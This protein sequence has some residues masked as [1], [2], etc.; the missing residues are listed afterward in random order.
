MN[1]QFDYAPVR[2]PTEAYLDRLA[3]ARWRE[4]VIPATSWGSPGMRI[5]NLEGIGGLEIGVISAMVLPVVQGIASGAYGRNFAFGIL[6]SDEPVTQWITAVS[7][8]SHAPIFLSASTV[9]TPRA[10]RPVGTLTATEAS[11]LDTVIALGGAATAAQLAAQ[12]QLEAAAAN[13]RLT[14]LERKGFLIRYAR[15]RRDGDLFVDPGTRAQSVE[16]ASQ[17]GQVAQVAEIELPAEVA[18]SVQAL[19]VQQ[20]RSPNVVLAEAWRM[21]L[22]SHI[23]E[24]NAAVAV[25]RLELDQADASPEGHIDE[26]AL[27]AWADAAAARMRD[28]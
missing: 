27:D 12:Q 3:A 22:E 20:G 11:T 19:A 13:N 1:L 25:A 15:N 28:E 6:T 8:A 10:I 7:A 23:D 4:Q 18:A 14:A 24:L 5:L 2:P 16:S 9:Q 21:Y 26:P 17:P